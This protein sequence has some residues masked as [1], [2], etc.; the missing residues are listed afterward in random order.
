MR[1]LIV[2]DLHANL[3]ALN[4]VVRQAAGRY[5]QAICCGDLVG[6]GA[7]PNPVTDWVRANCAI[8][9]RGNHDRA[10]S[11][12]DDLEWFNPVARIAAVWTL[13]NLS[14]GNADYIRGLPQGPV[15]V[16]GFEVVHGSPYDE[17]EYVLAAGEAGQAFGYLEARLAFFGHTHV[18]GGFIWNQSRVE[19][20][21]RTAAR[22]DRQRMEIDPECAYLVNPGSVG[23]PRD[24]DPRA[25]YAVYDSGAQM[26]T[27]FRAAYDVEAAQK[28]IR[29]V[30]L[31]P[32]LADRLS[33]GR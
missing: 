29:E 24:G 19:T 23:Q 30:G 27:Y 2:S 12:L 21:A 11:G 8:V 28:R 31:P 26:L 20:I 15:L 32:V 17:D 10:S 14:A 1:Y 18:Q 22:T 5:D 6:Y 33:V 25:A 3:E 13:E 4:A 16:D 7:D 9:V